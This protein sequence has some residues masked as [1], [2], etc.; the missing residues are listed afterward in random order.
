MNH[1]SSSIS[2]LALG[3][4]IY[5][6]STLTSMAMMGIGL[7][8][9]GACY[10]LALK[11][12]QVLPGPLL[13]I[14]TATKKRYALIS[15]ALV[16][17][18]LISLVGAWAFPVHY[19]GHSPRL[20]WGADLSKLGYF[21]LP[22]V[23]AHLFSRLPQKEYARVVRVWLLFAG[24]ISFIAI[25]QF[26]TGWP[27]PQGIPE[28]SGHFHATLF[29]GHHLST[30]SILIFPCFLALSLAASSW[31][32]KSPKTEGPSANEFQIGLNPLILALIGTLG[33]IALFLTW[34]R[35]V[36]V[37]LPLGLGVW[38]FRYFDRR[39]AAAFVGAMAL[40]GLIAIPQVPQLRNRLSSDMGTSDR[41][42]LWRANI[43][44]FEARPWT[45]IGWKKA[46]G[47]TTAY[48]E[49]V[50][51]GDASRRFVGHA[52]NNFLDVLSGTGL[53]GA[54]T[55][56]AWSLLMFQ[57]SWILS[58]RRDFWGELGWAYFCAWIVF[59]INGLTQVNFWEGKVMHQVMWGAALIL[60]SSAATARSDL[61][62]N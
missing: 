13:E 26:F 19:A 46:E 9:L 25:P 62:K 48:Y 15:T 57:M 44:F 5:G 33:L 24:L 55:W 45:G 54:F 31:F 42:E 20:Q 18:C 60:F 3:L 58:R 34:S 50:Y 27:R 11:N 49:E 1:P 7:G 29:F 61:R 43:A 39:K 17:V 41:F 40:A 32:R 35:M 4:S 52:H 53:I 21:A 12:G 6:A 28:F 36:W 51:G 16:G 30:A 22:L 14:D 59:Q 56:I 47:L 23:L 37:A 2:L 8:T 10:G 38:I